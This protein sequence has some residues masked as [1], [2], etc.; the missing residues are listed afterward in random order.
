M[1]IERLKSLK[2]NPSLVRLKEK[3]STANVSI[4]VV[5]VVMLW[6]GVWGILDTYFFPTFLPLRY[7]IGVLLGALV[8][9]LDDF[10]L[11]DI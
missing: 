6:W 2:N 5:A 10:S 9:Y 4:V 7:L 1:L 3:Y 8:L 11:E